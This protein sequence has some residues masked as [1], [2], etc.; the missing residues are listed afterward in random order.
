MSYGRLPRG[1]LAMA[2]EAAEQLGLRLEAHVHDWIR[3]QWPVAVDTAG[4]L[5]P[6]DP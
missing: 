5:V 2:G 3:E 4:R 1:Y 6:H